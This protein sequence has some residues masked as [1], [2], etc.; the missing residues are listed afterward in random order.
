MDINFIASVLGMFIGLA[1]AIGLWGAVAA[2][3]DWLEEKWRN[4]K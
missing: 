3:L 2:G 1:I 4:R